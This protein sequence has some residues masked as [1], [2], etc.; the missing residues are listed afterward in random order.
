MAFHD[1]FWFL[2]ANPFRKDQSKQQISWKNSGFVDSEFVKT[3]DEL[4]IEHGRVGHISFPIPDDLP[5]LKDYEE[6]KSGW[7]TLKKKLPK[8]LNNLLWSYVLL[9]L[10]FLIYKNLNAN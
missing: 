4:V 7:Q 10:I 1:L 3:C 9:G 5:V 2:N 8:I 6:P